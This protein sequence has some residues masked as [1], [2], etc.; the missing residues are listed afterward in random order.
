MNQ[1]VRIAVIASAALISAAA[2]AGCSTSI[3]D[4]DSSS[5]SA[6]VG[7]SQVLPPVIIEPGQTQASAKVGDTI[8]INAADPVKTTISTSTP[9]LVEITQGYDD[10]SATFNPGAKA[11]AAGTA[12]ITV[13]PAVGASYDLTISIAE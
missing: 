13:T 11:L 3:D 4:R 7:G 9:E 2:L 10:G 8:V 6:Q 5:P 1:P 12:V